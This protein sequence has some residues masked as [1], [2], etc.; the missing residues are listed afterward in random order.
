[1]RRVV[2][3]VPIG[4]GKTRWRLRVEDD[5]S[6]SENPNYVDARLIAFLG[7]L[8]GSPSLLHCGPVYFRKASL[9]HDG[10]AWVLEAETEA[11]GA[12][13]T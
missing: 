13:S 5:K 4:E 6:D 3:A 2:K 12:Q 11:P 8:A 7:T 9:Y 1:M 10:K